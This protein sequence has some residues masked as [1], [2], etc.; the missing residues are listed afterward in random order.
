[1]KKYRLA[2]EDWTCI[3]SK[4]TYSKRVDSELFKGYLGLIYIHQVTEPQIWRFNNEDIVS[5]DKGMKWLTILPQDEFYC[6]TVMFDEN[7]D[8]NGWYIDMIA[9]QGIDSDGVTYIDDLY[10]DLVV[11]P[12]GTVLEDD[13]DELE[14][15]LTQG[16][17]TQELFDLAINTGKKLKNGLLSDIDV[18]KEYTVK[19]FNM[20]AGSENN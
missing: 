6:I 12:D 15:A 11:Y 14:K 19:C 10:L 9:G 13:M 18:F 3:L 20:I 5:C 1:M 2:Y 8:I 7:N 16:D 17:I 4:D